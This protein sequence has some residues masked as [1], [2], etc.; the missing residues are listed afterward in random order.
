VAQT[1]THIV[2][3]LLDRGDLVAQAT[4]TA[5]PKADAGKHLEAEEFK[6]ITSET[7]GWQMEEIVEAGEMPTEAGRYV[8]RISARGIMDEVKV[9]Q[10]F[11]LIAGANGDQVIITLTLKPNQASKLGTRDLTLVGSIGFP[12]K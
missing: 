4:I 12:K 7:P 2:L 9:I 1:D 8:Y 5:W 10:Y 11:Y 3:R 6:K